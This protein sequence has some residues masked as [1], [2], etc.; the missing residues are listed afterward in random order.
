MYIYCIY[1]I[2]VYTNDSP[3]VVS[4]IVLFPLLYGF[5]NFHFAENIN[6]WHLLY[7]NLNYYVSIIVRM[8]QNILV[9]FKVKQLI[10]ENFEANILNFIQAMY[11]HRKP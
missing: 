3:Y 10:F 2:Y 1:T 11:R 6:L 9:D 4:I 5:S 8:I 7:E